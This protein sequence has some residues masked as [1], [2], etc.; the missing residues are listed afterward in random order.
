MSF[1]PTAEQQAI[2]AHDLTKHARILAGPGTGKSAT[3]I[4]LLD[5]NGATLGKYAKLLTFT[6]AATAELAHKLSENPE[7]ACER[8]S[9][10]HSFCISVL[11]RNP[12]LGEFPKPLRMADDWEADKI[13]EETLARRLQIPKRRVS[14]LFAELAANWESLSPEK[15]PKVS[16]E[17]RA[18]FMGGWREHRDVFGYTLPAELPYA[19]LMA[20]RD[21]GDLAG[22][23]YKL[24]VV[25][26]Y[27][28][29][30]ACDLDVLREL[31]RLS[32]K[33]IAAGDDDQ[34][35]YSFRKAHPAGIRR[36]LQDFPGARDYPLTLT[37]RCGRKIV[38]WANFVI[39]G[40]PDRPAFRPALTATLEAP[41]GEVRLLSFDSE[42][43]E[44][45]AVAEI[46]SHLI[47][48]K[49]VPPSEILIMSRSDH[50]GQFSR[51]IKETLKKKGI[52][53]SDISSLT[54]LME[55]PDTRLTLS[56]L[57]LL[58]NK[59]DSLAWATIFYFT[60]GVGDAFTDYAYNYARQ[61]RMSLGKAWLHLHS[62]SFPDGPA[63]STPRAKA[64]M[65]GVLNWLE[66]VDN[67]P[68]CEPTCGWT[69]WMEQALQSGRAP[70]P[71][72]LKNLFS[73]VSEKMEPTDE[74]GRYLSQLWPLARDIALAKGTGVRI[75][76][77]G[78]SKGLTVEAAII[79]CLENGV[80]PMDQRELGEER[81]LLYVGMT[82]A[83]RFLF[84]TWARRRQGPTARAGRAHVGQPRQLSYFLEGGPVQSVPA[85]YPLFP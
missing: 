25:D 29:L 7:V 50:N 79:V 46:A 76:T 32:C 74:M 24:L 18:R 64:V 63:G 44:A 70:M 6:R 80:V 1:K 36:F 14:D 15:S 8:P 31:A 68:D 71:P 23:N 56:H 59:E 40:D 30:N 35:I 78:G 37:H 66:T 58:L 69:P 57:R 19:L 65:D 20:L 55:E 33:L 41:E 12:G 11:L 83:R 38:D 60:N 42:I 27:Q 43:A 2:I 54:E 21:H 84:G 67:I 10:V 73:T 72:A 81:R 5:A 28:D 47:A 53:Y 9:T 34:S 49:K 13:V 61:N 4:E 45:R 51:P 85:R 39:K 77:L 82:R 62:K 52:S 16:P 17:Q 26:E 3:I 48:N 22:L 75:M